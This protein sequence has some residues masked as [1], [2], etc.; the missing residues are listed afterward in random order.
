MNNPFISMDFN[1]V[2][3]GS[4]RGP[5]AHMPAMDVMWVSFYSIG[6]MIL[7]VIMVTLARKWIKNNILSFLIRLIALIIFL[8][9]TLLMVLVISTWPA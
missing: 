6:A 7:S 5:L 2:V 8:V 3:M 9:G 1:K 4:L